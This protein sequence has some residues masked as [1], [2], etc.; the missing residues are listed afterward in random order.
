[1]AMPDSITHGRLTLER[2]RPHHA[3]PL[4]DAANAS[5]AELGQW[6]PWAAHGPIATESVASSIEASAR[7][8]DSG[9]DYEYAIIQSGEFLGCVAL[10]A[11]SSDQ[12]AEVGYWVRTDRTQRG[13]AT[14]AVVAVTTA[15]FRVLPE[16]REVVIR[17]D[18][19]NRASSRVAAKS[20]LRLERYEQ[21]D[22]VTAGHTG[23][24]EV[25]AVLRSE[26]QT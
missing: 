24:G 12:R 4:A 9:F 23:L 26:W 13:V 5:L 21:R 7:R 8:F 6:L 11:Q 1:M 25:W 17:L 19:A 22:V 20:G 2:W 16:V 15:A 10:H 14:A 3:G 18:A